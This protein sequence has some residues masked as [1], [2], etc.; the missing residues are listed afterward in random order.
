MNMMNGKEGRGNGTLFACPLWSSHV[1]CSFYYQLKGVTTA[2]AVF[3]TLRR[4]NKHS[5][6]I[7]KSKVTIIRPDLFLL[8]E[9]IWWG[10]FRDEF[11]PL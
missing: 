4:D 10:C 6:T 2:A 1:P 5:L 3:G 11:W 8:N 9:I 7:Q